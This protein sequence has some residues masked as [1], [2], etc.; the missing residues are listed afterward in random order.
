LSN[1]HKLDHNGSFRSLIIGGNHP[2]HIHPPPRKLS[3]IV[4]AQ[5]VRT[6]L[7]ASLRL[8]RLVWTA[9]SC[10]SQLTVVYSANRLHVWGGP[11]TQAAEPSSQ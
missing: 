4:S 6:C 10:Q 8:I 11:E 3:L 1:R 5:R 9:L 7:L 2:G